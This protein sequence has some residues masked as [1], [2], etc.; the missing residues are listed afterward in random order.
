MGISTANVTVTAAAKA[1]LSAV[2]VTTLDV[3]NIEIDIKKEMIFI[4]KADGQRVEYPYDAISTF[5]WV[6]AGGVA[7]ITIS[8]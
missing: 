5:T 2:A 6:I 3:R 1:G 8:T 7:T 4:T